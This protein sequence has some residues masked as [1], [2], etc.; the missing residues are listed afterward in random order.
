MQNRCVVLVGAVAAAFAAIAS[1]APA[2][3]LWPAIPPEVGVA[4]RIGPVWLD[5]RCTA[6]PVMN[7][8]HGAY[9]GEEPPAL[10]H[11]YAYRPYYRYSAYRK[12]PR[13]YFCVEAD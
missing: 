11:G 8:Y 12:W 2:G 13:T 5:Y 9:Y 4:P 10:Q 7:F 3:E 1:P 6:G